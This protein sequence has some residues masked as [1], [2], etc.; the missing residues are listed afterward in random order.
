MVKK[1]AKIEKS[2]KILVEGTGSRSSRSNSGNSSSTYVR[3]SSSSSS[4][5]GGGSSFNHGNGNKTSDSSISSS[6]KM[7]IEESP[8]CLDNKGDLKNGNYFGNYLP[9]DNKFELVSGAYENKDNNTIDKD[10]NQAVTDYSNKYDNDN[11]EQ[12]Y[13][14]CSTDDNDKD[15]D[16]NNDNKEINHIDTD[17]CNYDKGSMSWKQSIGDKTLSENF[18]DKDVKNIQINNNANN[19]ATLESF[20]D[21]TI[22]NDVDSDSNAIK[23]KKIHWDH[24]ISIFKDISSVFPVRCEGFFILIDICNNLNSWNTRYLSGVLHHYPSLSHYESVAT[25]KLSSGKSANLSSANLILSAN[26]SSAN[27][28]STNP[29]GANPSSANPSSAN[30]SSANP[31]SANPSSANPS[32]ANPSSANPSSANPSSAIPS[33]ANLSSTVDPSDPKIPFNEVLSNGDP[34][35]VKPTLGSQL[36]DGSRLCMFNMQN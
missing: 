6:D 31:S 8:V 15:K 2:I 26:P 29:F 34:S 16:M 18:N 19:C 27:P 4:I 28:S 3:A 13:W 32:S 7:M 20:T 36:S 1:V 5:S 22:D 33:S 24:L 30:P 21:G 9:I 14:K 35:R 25:A 11:Q 12:K 17:T 23:Y 10:V